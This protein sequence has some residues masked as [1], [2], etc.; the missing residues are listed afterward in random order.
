MAKQSQKKCKPAVA[1]AQRNKRSSTK[2][3][4]LASARAAA[5]QDRRR[6]DRSSWELGQD[7]FGT[8]RSHL[9]MRNTSG[10]VKDLI[11]ARIRSK[12]SR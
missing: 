11:R 2:G 9:E 3:M 5:E 12:S 6:G 7:L 10:R 4:F 1:S 8:D